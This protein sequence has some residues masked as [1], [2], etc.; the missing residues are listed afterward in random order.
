MAQSKYFARM[1]RLSA[2]I[3]GEVSRP[4]SLKA[5]KVVKLFSQPYYHEK[6]EFVSYYPKHEDI[7]DLMNCLRYHGLFR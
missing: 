3:F 7:S 1:A 6:S 2:K 5:S 4:E